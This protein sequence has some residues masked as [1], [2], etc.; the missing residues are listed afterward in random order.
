MVGRSWKHALA[1]TFHS[2]GVKSCAARRAGGLKSNFTILDVDD[3]IRVIKQILEAEKLDE[4]RW[5][6][7]CSPCSSTAGRTVASR[8]SRSIAS[9]ELCQR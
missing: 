5:R 7:A 3:Q 1:R 9:R 4:K 2:I 6:R 8:L